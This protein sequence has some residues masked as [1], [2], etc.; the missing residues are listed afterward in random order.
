M[1]LKHV[2]IKF[3]EHINFHIRQDIYSDNKTRFFLIK[4]RLT[5]IAGEIKYK[6]GPKL[7]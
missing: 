7:H 5:S 6:L 3:L 4:K 1:T 2:Q